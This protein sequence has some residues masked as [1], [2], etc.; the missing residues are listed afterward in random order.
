MKVGN[1]F[2]L[3]EYLLEEICPAV[4]P[5]VFKRCLHTLQTSY[6][7]HHQLLK[8]C[9]MASDILSGTEK[10]VHKLHRNINVDRF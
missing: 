2:Q 4:T 10:H 3:P 8:G 7:L 1:L 9:N 5:A 6:N